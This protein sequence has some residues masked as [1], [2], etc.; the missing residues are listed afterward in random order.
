M[1]K[2]VMSLYPGTHIK[3]RRQNLVF[4]GHGPNF[5]LNEWKTSGRLGHNVRK[6]RL[7]NTVTGSF[8]TIMGQMAEMSQQKNAG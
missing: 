6:H 5:F 7:V 8:N 4:F 1:G 3:N 2:K